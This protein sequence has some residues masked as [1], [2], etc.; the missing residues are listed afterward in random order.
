MYNLYIYIYR[1]QINQNFCS[2]KNERS[3]R[4]ELCACCRQKFS[5]TDLHK[6]HWENASLRSCSWY[7]RTVTQQSFGTFSNH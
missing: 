6:L 2:S 5:I 7:N 1:G 4:R 3:E